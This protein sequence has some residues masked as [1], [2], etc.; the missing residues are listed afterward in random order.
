MT[1]HGPS[2]APAAVDV[3]AGLDLA[4]HYREFT[5]LGRH[6]AETRAA[7]LAVRR[8]FGPP[9]DWGYDTL[10]GAALLALYDL[11]NRLAAP[12]RAGD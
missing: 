8:A 9:G 11:H 10:Q 6:L 4:Q 12:E 5:D 3:F 1:G 2:P 7:I